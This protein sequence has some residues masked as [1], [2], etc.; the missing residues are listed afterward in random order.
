MSTLYPG[1]DVAGDWSVDGY[2]D[3]ISEGPSTQGG[4]VDCVIITTDALA[5]E[6]ERL[7]VW[8]DKMGV[9]TVVRTLSWIEGRY[10]G[11]DSAERVR[12]FLRDAY[13]R[14]GTV[15]V[16]LG[17][18]ATV[19]PIR[20]AWTSHYGGAFIPTDLYYSNLEGNLERR[21]RRDIRGIR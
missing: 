12:G 9:R 19:M 21:R 4:A 2:A 3:W 18:D 15:Y 14:W 8:H 5:S 17:G 7:A 1:I 11:S 13:Q 6:F 16:L 20:Y 10:S